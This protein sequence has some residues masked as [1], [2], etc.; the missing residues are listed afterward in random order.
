[1]QRRVH[2]RQR[3]SS[4]RARQGS[5]TPAPSPSLVTRAGQEA[6]GGRLWLGALAFSQSLTHT[7]SIWA[8]PCWA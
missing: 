8:G 5:E 1:M 6:T 7:P 2:R 4:E 3:R